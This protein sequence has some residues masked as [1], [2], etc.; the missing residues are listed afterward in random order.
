MNSS[1][2][3]LIPAPS[4]GRT[5]TSCS[6]TSRSNTG[7][8]AH[9]AITDIYPLPCPCG[10]ILECPFARVAPST[11]GI[12]SSQGS[13]SPTTCMASVIWRDA[14]APFFHCFSYPFFRRLEV[15][16][17]ALER[18]KNRQQIDQKS[19]T[20]ASLISISFFDRF[21]IALL[22]NNQPPEPSKS[23]FPCWFFDDLAFLAFYQ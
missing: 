8:R 13:P 5:A 11:T 20:H 21:L 6:E 9:I 3:E 22:L 14:A 16:D 1:R 15:Q 12:E 7:C 19:I 2:C 23:L 17:F 4:G 10:T 18:F